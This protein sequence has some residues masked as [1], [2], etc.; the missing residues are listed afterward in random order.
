MPGFLRFGAFL[1]QT[2]CQTMQTTGGPK[3]DG[4]QTEADGMR[5]VRMAG[6][7]LVGD[8]GVKVLR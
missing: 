1:K 4:K 7:L 2:V 3:A 8:L 5:T 6:G